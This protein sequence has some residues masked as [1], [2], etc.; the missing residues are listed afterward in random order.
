M[1]TI[2]LDKNYMCHLE[3]D[4]KRAEL[5]T[6][7]FDGI[8]DGAIEYYRYIPQGKSWESENGTILHGLY[9]QAT[10]SEAIDREIRKALISDMQT[11][12]EILGVRE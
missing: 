9:V 6:D 10:N 7:I 8:A 3:N 2:Y 5:Q 4:G 1:K 12:L 11:A